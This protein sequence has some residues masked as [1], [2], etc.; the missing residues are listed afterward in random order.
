[1]DSTMPDSSQAPAPIAGPSSTNDPANAQSGPVALI[2]AGAVVLCLM[3]M[4][5]SCAAGASSL[6]FR[7]LS[8]YSSS[9][10]SSALGNSYG[11]GYGYNDEYGYG[12]NGYGE[13]GLGSNSG[14]DE[15]W[16]PIH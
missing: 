12:D 8:A 13:H 6:I 16:Y 1:M 11:D 10:P 2:I 5:T 14:S 3:A 15:Y 9:S 4:A 7:Y